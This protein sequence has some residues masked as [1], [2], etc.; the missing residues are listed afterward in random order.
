MCYLSKSKFQSYHIAEYGDAKGLVRKPNQGASTIKLFAEAPIL[1]LP[2]YT[3]I[4]NLASR[5]EEYHLKSNKS[6]QYLFGIIS[7]SVFFNY[8]S[9]QIYTLISKYLKM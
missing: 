3:N 5:S 4:K 1:P 2:R 9:N 7:G 8:K 6:K